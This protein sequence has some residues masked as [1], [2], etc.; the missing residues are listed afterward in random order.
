MKRLL[1]G[2]ALAALSLCLSHPAHAWLTDGHS[3]IAAAAV[4]SLPEDV[5][6]WFR[7]GGAQIAH[8]AQDPDI[9][10]S[11]DLP[12]MNDAES[13]Q[14]YIDIELLGGKPLPTSRKAFYALCQELKQDPSYVGELPYALAEWTQRLTMT[15]AEA[16]MY[17]NNPYI[18]TKSLVYAG[19]LT[20]YAG[21]A[22]MPLHVTID[23]DGRTKADGTSP[24][25][26]IH[27][28]MDAVIERLKLSP[29]ALAKDQQAKAFPELFPA[30]ESQ[31]KDTQSKIEL[32][33]QLEAQLPP[34]S[35]KDGWTPSSAI[36]DLANERGRAATNF[37]ASLL[38]SAWR[39]SAKIKM[40]DWYKRTDGPQ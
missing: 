17:P 4:K 16:R 24:R 11:R 38:L 40:P 1:S 15:F 22:C 39:D 37:A 36:Q 14:H 18:R 19:I 29:E 9:Q 30:I 28:R 12:F 26:G 5:P 34:K 3:T 27:L 31:I 8:D 20:H 10:K 6:I 35:E 23:H 33:Y 25:S 2:T 32:V 13:P 21:D 7:E